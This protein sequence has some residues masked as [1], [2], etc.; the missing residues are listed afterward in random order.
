MEALLL[1][2]S[3]YKQDEV[4]GTGTDAAG[5]DGGWEMTP[6]RDQMMYVDV[7]FYCLIL[8][9]IS[10][11]CWFICSMLPYLSGWTDWFPLLLVI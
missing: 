9:P 5:A 8:L 1:L 3:N 6:C 11:T 7:C 4:P 10:V 2:I